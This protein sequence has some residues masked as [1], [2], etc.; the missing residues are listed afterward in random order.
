MCCKLMP[1]A[2]TGKEAGVRC[3][4]QRHRKGC[5]IYTIRPA[6]CR[7]WGC[8]WLMSLELEDLRRPDVAGYVIDPTAD[9]M[10][11]QGGPLGS[12]EERFR[13]IQIWCDPKRPD[14]HRDPALRAYLEDQAKEDYVGV[15]RFGKV[16]GLALIPP[17][18]SG[19]GWVEFPT[20]SAGREHTLAE[21]I[22]HFG[23]DG[24]PQAFVDVMKGAHPR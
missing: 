22:G 6:S 2:E 19:K 17:A 5:S 8:V 20:T 12:Q 9:F 16:E 23:T 18:W 24:L 10:V 21:Y 3:S 4:H 13:M 11:A 7:W 1:I 14:A 15:V